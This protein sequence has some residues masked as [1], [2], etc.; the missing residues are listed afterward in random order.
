MARRIVNTAPLPAASAPRTCAPFTHQQVILTDA[1]GLPS[2]ARINPSGGALAA[3]PM[4][5][6]GLE[7]IGFAASRAHHADDRDGLAGLTGF[8]LFGF[9]WNMRGLALATSAPSQ[10]PSRALKNSGSLNGSPWGLPLTVIT[11]PV[12]A[13]SMSLPTRNC[14]AVSLSTARL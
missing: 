8:G 1:V 7:R 10:M 9:D 3:H 2:S 6:A 11:V 12:P 4:F 13:T 14:P 5:S